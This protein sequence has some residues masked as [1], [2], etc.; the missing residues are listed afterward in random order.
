[1]LYAFYG[2]DRESVVKES[3]AKID[4]LLSDAPDM[5][6]FTLG[7]E[8]LSP[9]EIDRHIGS[10][11]LFNENHVILV[12]GAFVEEE[13]RDA[14]TERLPKMASSGNTFI[15]REGKLPVAVI[16]ALTE[17][18]DEE[19]ELNVQKEGGKEAFS[20]FSL[21]DAL[22]ARDKKKLWILYQEALREGIAVEEIHG[23]LVWQIKTLVQI[24]KGETGTLKPF[25]VSKGKRGLLNYPNHEAEKLWFTLIDI[26]HQSRRGELELS[27]AL[28]KFI[29]AL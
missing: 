16:R 7:D 8:T 10:Q 29:L 28:E 18:A 15:L 14:M 3:R 17:H 19:V 24:E 9:E 23:V 11:G 6:V 26:Y 1:M 12:D 21:T 4:A 27:L 25:V 5:N 20:I 22:S 2:T 13:T